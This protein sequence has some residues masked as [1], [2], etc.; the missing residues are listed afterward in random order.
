MKDMQ[1][2]LDKLR[3][4]ATARSVVAKPAKDRA[5]REL[6]TRLAKQGNLLAGE[7]Q[8]AMTGSAKS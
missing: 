2:Q 3:A 4:E 1:A 7:V 6:F 8:K 5:R